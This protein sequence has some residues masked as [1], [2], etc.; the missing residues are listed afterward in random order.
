M[1]GPGA[2]PAG[3]ARC[4]GP[5]RPGQ[6]A[7]PGG[8]PGARSPGAGPRGRQV[9]AG[10]KRRAGGVPGHAAGAGAVHLPGGEQVHGQRRVERSGRAGQAQAAPLGHGAGPRRSLGGLGCG[11]AA[12]AR[13]AGGLARRA[14]GG[15][16]VTWL[17]GGG[18]GRAGV[19]QARGRRPGCGRPA[20]PRPRA[21]VRRARPPPPAP[22]PPIGWARALSPTRAQSR[23][24][25]GSPEVRFARPLPPATQ[26]A[27]PTRRGPRER[28]PA[29]AHRPRPERRAP[30]PGGGRE[31]LEGP[32]GPPA[33]LSPAA[34]APASASPR[35]PELCIPGSARSHALPASPDPPF[36]GRAPCPRPR[37]PG[38]PARR[39]RPW[40]P[41]EARP[42]R[43]PALCLRRP[44][45]PSPR[46]DSPGGSPRRDVEPE[47]RGCG[48]PAASP[49][50]TP[51]C[52]PRAHW[53]ARGSVCS[54]TNPLWSVL[55]LPQPP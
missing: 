53:G 39:P 5:G 37:L 46:P 19:G 48:G 6:G 3:R 44:L 54:S 15:G 1:D 42:P 29:P 4:A 17:P 22:P 8:G 50:P 35:P 20:P 7:G 23:P 21:R 33:T 38:P 14:E 49:S 2:R 47:H 32:Q 12:D 18:A 10:T 31:G 36:P 55:C 45:A 41:P 52:C 24:A 28:A 27:P 16:A 25:E 30:P 34:P 9:R 26:E 43:E 51:S 13:R 11:R 40:C